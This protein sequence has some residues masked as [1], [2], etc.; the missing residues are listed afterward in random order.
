MTGRRLDLA[1]GAV[2]GAVAAAALGGCAARTPPALIEAPLAFGRDDICAIAA[3]PEEPGR[4]EMG[5]DG[6]GRARADEIVRIAQWQEVR[7]R[8]D[9]RR[10]RLRGPWGRCD[11]VDPGFQTLSFSTDGR[12]ARTYGSWIAAPLFGGGGHCL[13]EKADGQ[14]RPVACE[15]TE[16]V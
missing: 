5:L 2:V 16:A 10:H 15:V 4:E 14:W 6:P 9:R 3:R 8:Y 13:Y 1:R 11:K 12:F 7:W